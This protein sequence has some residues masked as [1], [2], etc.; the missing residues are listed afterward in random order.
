MIPPDT[1][2]QWRFR[3]C[4]KYQFWC[5]QKHLPPA[6]Y[7]PYRTLKHDLKGRVL[8]CLD[9][10]RFRRA[11]L[12]EGA[13]G[14]CADGKGRDVTDRLQWQA[15]VYQALRGKVRMP[16]VY[17]LYHKGGRT[18]LALE[19]VEGYT[20]HDAVQ[21]VLGGQPVFAA[22]AEGWERLK[23]LLRRV[24]EN[25]GRMHA[26]GYV[27]RDLMTRNILVLEKGGVVFTDFELAYS[28]EGQVPLP[29]FGL[30]SAGFMA[31]EQ[32]AGAEPA[33]A[34]DI[35]AL[36]AVLAEVFTGLSPTRFDTGDNCVLRD[37]LFYFTR[38][39]G[40]SQMTSECLAADPT[41]RPG[42]EEVGVRL[43]AAGP[44][45]VPTGQ[46]AMD[47]P[48]LK[49]LI[50]DAIRGLVSRKLTDRKAVWWSK[51]V[52]AGQAAANA[53]FEFTAR[54]GLGEGIAGV[55]YLLAVAKTAGY[56]IS[57]CAEA[58]QANLAFLE[59]HFLVTIPALPPGLLHGAWGVGVGLAAAV[60]AGLLEDSPGWRG[61]I[62][63]CLAVPGGG[64]AGK[65]MA[66]LLCEGFCEP[67]AAAP[68]V[69]A[70]VMEGHAI[71]NNG[72]FTGTAG[73]ALALLDAGRRDGAALAAADR[74]LERLSKEDLLRAG[75]WL[76]EGFAGVALVFARG[77]TL[78]GD[79]RY[80]AAA[81]RL[82]RLVPMYVTDNSLDIAH[83]LA[84]LG[85]A[86]LEAEK[87]FG[88]GEWLA[89]ADWIAG[90]LALTSFRQGDGSV[91]WNT[92]HT[93]LPTADLLAG[94]AGIIYF[95]IQYNV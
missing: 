44:A 71:K 27:Y 83:G 86:Y 34:E 50:E 46:A 94:N 40:L 38:A 31:P 15:A 5:I 30:G 59:R 62:T 61:L 85:L 56:D 26:A 67:E 37:K 84:G 52:P 66:L 7:L 29:P 89:R 9:L 22:G 63:D 17:G 82:L 4:K 95:L 60:R 93:M 81:E 80:K 11:V 51:R 87:S 36:G 78:L 65:Y 45:H 3:S 57:G 18:W 72:L 41:Q 25:L 28:I 19:Y 49:I 35:Y 91:Y 12:K 70:L 24:I 47:K 79:G 48:A 92:D 6:R 39:S 69:P 1:A 55:L 20:L 75:P 88:G 43:K 58:V 64:A 90:V 42:L 77:F 8:L 13:A 10:L 76:G 32:E 23:T 33:P 14:Q 73:Y 2:T 68:M 21:G 74:L 54:M 53:T 16:A